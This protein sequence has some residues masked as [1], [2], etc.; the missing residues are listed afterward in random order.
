M[1]RPIKVT[2]KPDKTIYLKIQFARTTT[3]ASFS[4]KNNI[5]GANNN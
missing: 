1:S 3:V 5:P 4:I 2:E